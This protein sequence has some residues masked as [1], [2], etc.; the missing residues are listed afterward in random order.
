[1]GDFNADFSTIFKLKWWRWYSMIY[2]GRLQLPLAY[3]ETD[4]V[5]IFWGN[6]WLHHDSLF[7]PHPASFTLIRRPSP[8]LWL[9]SWLSCSYSDLPSMLLTQNLC[10]NCSICM[11]HF[12]LIS[13]LPS[14][15]HAG[16]SPDIT[17]SERLSV[18]NRLNINLTTARLV[19]Y[20]LTLLFFSP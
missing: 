5:G 19:L 12:S 7:S 17:I 10:I 15:C 16:F 9:S 14:L 3:T 8:C 20:H 6:H 13:Y 4:T 18:T 2:S 1:M 11:Q